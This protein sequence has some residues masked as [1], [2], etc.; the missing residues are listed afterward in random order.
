MIRG[1]KVILYGIF[2]QGNNCSVDNRGQKSLSQI[3]GVSVVVR[4]TQD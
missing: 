1:E 3:T 4:L 2:R